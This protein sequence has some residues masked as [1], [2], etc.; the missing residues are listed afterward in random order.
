MV[1]CLHYDDVAENL[2]ADHDR[3]QHQR[4]AGARVRNQWIT[5]GQGWGSD[6]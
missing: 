6:P 1:G 3:G 4:V 2:V 5:R